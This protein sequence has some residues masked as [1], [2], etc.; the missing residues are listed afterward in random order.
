MDPRIV[1][2]MAR[3]HGL[4]TRRQALTLGLSEKEVRQFVATGTWIPVHRGVY[5]LASAWTELDRWVEQPRLRSLAVGMQLTVDHV[6]SHDS[7]ADLLGL[8]ILRARP[9]LV[10]VTREGVTGSR[11][12]HGVKHHGAVYHDSQVE[13]AFGVPVLNLARTAVDIAREHGLV[14]GL[15]A[16]DAARRRGEA[17]HQLQAACA[18]MRHWKGVPAARRSIELSDPGAETVGESLMRLM[19]LE[20]GIGEPETQFEIRDA[21]GWVRCDVRVGRH[22]F[23]FDGR[24]K[25]LRPVDGGVARDPALAAW[26]EKLRQDWVTRHRLGVSRVTWAELWGQRRVHAKR[27]L[28]SEY[29]ETEA[30]YGTSIDDLAH[31]IVVR[32]SA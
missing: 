27:R 25:Y 3:Q 5:A 23:E 11:N 12:L 9:D 6:F 28:E 18:P 29:R 14:H 26:N 19:I 20:I 13:T 7:A 31:L 1:G 30:R 17:V 10:H 22:I 32:R 4:I 21:D 2:Q 15:P 16:C 24:K 8:P